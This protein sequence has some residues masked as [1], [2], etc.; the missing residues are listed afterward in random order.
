MVLESF[1][2]KHCGLADISTDIEAD[3]T[4]EISTDIA[5][6]ITADITANITSDIADEDFSINYPLYQ[7]ALVDSCN[8]EIHHYQLLL[9]K[10]VFFLLDNNQHLVP[11]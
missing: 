4:A 10:C 7:M 2:A 6:D 9:L 5:A 1:E 8:A 3:I 11:F